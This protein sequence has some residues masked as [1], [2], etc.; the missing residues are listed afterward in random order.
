MKLCSKLALLLGLGSLV[1]AGCGGGSSS[2][3]AAATAPITLFATDNLSS[4]DHVW[5][6]LFKIDLVSSTGALVTVY[7]NSTGETI[8]LRSLRDGTGARYQL[9]S[10]LN[11]PA[12]TY[13][14]AKVTVA[15]AVTLFA[16]G[17]ATGDD[18]NFAVNAGDPAGKTVMTLTFAS[19]KTF[20]TTSSNVVLDFDLSQWDDNPSGV[21]PVVIEGSG[22]SLDDPARHEADD[23]HGLIS[24]LTGTAPT[25]S[26]TITLRGG[27]TVTVNTSASTTIFR[28]DATASPSLANGNR[29]EILGTFDPTSRTISATSIKV[30]DE[31]G[32][33]QPELYGHVS[34]FDATAGSMQ[35]VIGRASG[36]APNRTMITVA[37]TST[38]MFRGG[39][40][41]VVS[42]DVFFASLVGISNP[43]IEVEGAYNRET[44]VLTATKVKRHHEGGDDGG[45]IGEQEA[46]GTFTNVN[47]TA[48]TFTLTPNE[49]EGFSWSGG[50]SVTV[51]LGE[52]AHFEDQMGESVSR[53]T[54]F[55]A[56]TGNLQVKVYGRMGESGFVA[57]RLKLISRN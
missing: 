22:S 53:A 28:E 32:E 7:D 41:A 10:K 23:F 42:R 56:L 38:T 30:E 1:I 13:T 37:T 40:G 34:E 20:G 52:G 45:G 47:S 19:A 26:F 49:W 51:S 35:M 17:S 31:S 3:G 18:K 54:F 21:A 33:N 15:R 16:G 11:V 6:T 2:G 5:V 50:R 29:V 36:V 25:Q 27:G 57:R 9:L 12:G 44:G 14:A 39:G 55:G 46:R 4:H 8:D 48:F 43:E 24:A